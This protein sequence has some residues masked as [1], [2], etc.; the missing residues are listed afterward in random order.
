[1]QLKD[2]DYSRLFREVDRKES[3]SVEFEMIWRKA[4]RK[5]WTQK[6]SQSLKYNLALLSTLLILTPIIGSYLVHPFSNDKSIEAS[7]LNGEP[8]I[9]A[10]TQRKK[11][12]AIVIGESSLP[13]GTILEASLV[14]A[15][16]QTIIREEEILIGKGGA[17]SLS[18][19]IPEARK[20]YVLL[21]EL[22][23]HTQKQSVQK[24]IG[25][26]GENLY[27]SSQV[28]GVYHYFKDKELH[29]GFRLY[30]NID[31]ELINTERMMF[32]S[33]KSA[34]P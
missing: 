4:N 28:A 1:M 33:L 6:Y 13:N 3:S 21:L 14:D 22:F 2:K 7:L 27:N 34:V 12:E 16:L 24:L 23:P 8:V 29:T 15:R 5:K 26:K 32:G 31:R 25:R 10:T 30:G 18:F 11:H 20:D 17:F 19:G 9:Q